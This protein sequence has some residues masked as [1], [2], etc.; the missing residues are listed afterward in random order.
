MDRRSPS[1]QRRVPAEWEPQQAIWLSWPH[2]KET[3][4]GFYK[5]LP[6]FYAAWA[7]TLSQSTDVRMLVPPTQL[8]LA[9]KRLQVGD[10][11]L[12]RGRLEL[13]VVETNDAWV[14]DYGPTFV[15]D[16]HEDRLL[17]VD[18]RYNAWGGKYSR[19]EADDAAAAAICEHI[20]ID[21][22][23]SKLC[24]EGGAMETDG[25]GRLLT[26][27][28]CL[29]TDTRN[30][31]WSSEQIAMELHTQLGVTEIVWLTGGGLVGDDTD[32]H[33]DQLARFLDPENVVVAVCDDPDDPNHQPLEANY[34]QL[35]LW[36][37]ETDPQV[38]VHRLPI[39]AAREIN[40]Q[41]VPESYCNFLMLGRDRLLVPAFGQQAADDQARGTLQE[42]AH[43]AV[44]ETM[45]CRDLVWG[46]GALHCASRDQPLC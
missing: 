35:Q 16:R 11:S 28:E 8:A 14:R 15:Y 33:I 43:G 20:G 45:D 4:P 29:V 42:L 32:G 5:S 46:L 19:W 2:N 18:W 12:R 23:R 36:A 17:G 37:S 25:Q 26:T 38:Q 1:V 24:L 27:P 10:A 30:R 40:Q 41:R 39:P 6:A 22:V 44:V 3:W 31:G 34:R 7:E 9:K 21:S 13:V